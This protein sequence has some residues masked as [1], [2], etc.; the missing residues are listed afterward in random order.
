MS[1]KIEIE[2]DPQELLDYLEDAYGDWECGSPNSAG[3]GQLAEFDSM[4]LQCLIRD[5]VQECRRHQTVRE[6][7][8]Q[9]LKQA[10]ATNKRLSEALDLSEKT[11]SYFQSILKEITQQVAKETNTSFPKTWELSGALDTVLAT[12]SELVQALRSQ[13]K[14]TQRQEEAKRAALVNVLEELDSDALDEHYGS[15]WDEPRNK[16]NMPIG[17]KHKISGCCKRCSDALDRINKNY[18]L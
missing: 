17:N 16:D 10:V 3:C 2:K 5:L 11:R 1:P 18:K 6:G 14:E 4:C 9:A 15:C 8:L 12:K 7:N 13:I